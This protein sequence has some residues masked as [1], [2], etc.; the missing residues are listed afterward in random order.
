MDDALKSKDK[1]LTWLL[2]I[3]N[4]IY[5]NQNKGNKT[6]NHNINEIYH[7]QNIS[8]GNLVLFLLMVII[9]LIVKYEYSKI[10][11]FVKKIFFK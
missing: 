4:E 10:K 1:L 3:R 8:N 9:I 6:I 2:K 7:P 11:K 5:T